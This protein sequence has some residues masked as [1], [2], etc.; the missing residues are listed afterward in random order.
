MWG[1]MNINGTFGVLLVLLA[2]I[3]CK[4][5]DRKPAAQLRVV[6]DTAVM[7]GEAVVLKASD[8]NCG[9]IQSLQQSY[10][11]QWYLVVLGCLEDI[12]TAFVVS[13]EG[14]YLT[15]VTGTS[16]DGPLGWVSSDQAR[17]VLN[18]QA[19]SVIEYTRATGL[20]D[21]GD[22]PPEQGWPSPVQVEMPNWVPSKGDSAIPLQVRFRVVRVSSDDS[23]NIRAS[24]SASSPVIGSIPAC[25]RNIMLVDP[26]R[27]AALASLGSTQ[28][29]GQSK[30]WAQVQWGNSEGWVRKDYLSVALEFAGSA[31]QTE[32]RDQSY[33][34]R[35][36]ASS[37]Q[38]A[39]PDPRLLH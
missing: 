20:F 35:N 3:S 13:A 36:D 9:F 23:L 38:Q 6:G 34:I 24:P 31:K 25:G 15:R 18:G 14:N 4:P 16:Y 19:V 33:I 26:E 7:L 5:T 30:S 27:A 11:G 29:H 28:Q 39:Y 1:A 8:D 17:W 32:C 21:E 10:D 22:G 2:G 12:N 37:T